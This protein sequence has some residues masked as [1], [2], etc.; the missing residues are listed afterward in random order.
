MSIRTIVYV[1]YD[2][3]RNKLTLTG[4]NTGANN[5]TCK[6]DPDAGNEVT[7]Q[8]AGANTGDW[9][10]TGV[11]WTPAAP[12]VLQVVV[13]N[14]TIVLT[15]NDVVTNTV[16][17]NCTVNGASG[18]NRVASDPV[19]INKPTGGSIAMRASSGSY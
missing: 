3:T 14:G 12:N 9:Y 13:A 19:I 7:F 16:D 10:L 4:G 6:F 11:A 15:D 5:G 8:Q 17:F 1:T 18:G 2:V